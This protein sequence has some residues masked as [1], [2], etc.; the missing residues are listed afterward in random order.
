MRLWFGSGILFWHLFCLVFSELH[1]Y[2]VWSLT[3][4]SRNFPSLLLQ[5]ALLFLSPFLLLLV[6]PLHVCCAFC[7]YNHLSKV[8]LGF[9]TL[10]FFSLLLEVCTVRLGEAFLIRVQ[11]TN[12]PVKGYFH[13]F[14]NFFISS[15]SWWFFT[16][17]S[18]PLPT[19]CIC[20]WM[21]PTFSIKIFSTLI[22]VFFKR[23][24]MIW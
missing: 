21:L 16:R 1:H 13:F 9:F 20:S 3:L 2:V 14:S 12:D 6:F 8:F 18:I 15:I 4:L 10:F 23:K 19:L 17:I 22:I 24:L 5:I 7:T 11:F